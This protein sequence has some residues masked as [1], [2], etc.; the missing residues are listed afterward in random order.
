MSWIKK[1]SDIKIEEEL[2]F[3]SNKL[4]V[5]DAYEV[6]IVDAHLQASA[7]ENSK[8]VSL[9][10]GIEN[11]DKLTNRTFFTVLGRDGQT[12]FT[13]TRGGKTEKRQHFGLSSVNTLFG[14]ALGKEIFDCEPEEV[15]YD[16]WDNDKKEMVKEKGEGFPELIG[17][18]VGITYQMYREI[19]GQDSKEYGQITHF[20]NTET[21]LFYNEEDSDT[22]KLDK[23]LKNPKAFIIK[24]VEEIQRK[25][26][27][28]KKKEVAEGGEK[29]KSRW[30]R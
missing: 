19:K 3:E 6:K 23:W 25:S 11:E 13:S 10:I 16:K 7:D 17:K 9:V 18:T 21:G 26:S 22:R 28:G 14:I 29:P 1:E 2:D 30:G 8:S 5:T 20:F 4:E 12:F 24:E 27:F 15:E